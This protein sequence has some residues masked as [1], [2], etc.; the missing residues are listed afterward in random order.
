MPKLTA[1]LLNLLN[2]CTLPFRPRSSYNNPFAPFNL[3]EEPSEA[4]LSLISSNISA[5]YPAIRTISLHILPP[6]F[7]RSPLAD[8]TI[9]GKGERVVGGFLDGWTRRVGD[10]IMSKWIVII[11]CISMG[12]N[13]WLLSEV[14]RGALQPLPQEK[15]IPV[16]VPA[17]PVEKVNHEVK[18][19]PKVPAFVVD[20]SE[21]DDDEKHV[22]ELKRHVRRTR[23]ASECMQ[24][25]SEGRPQDLLDGEIIALTLQKKIPLYA[26]EKTLK[27]LERAVKIRRAAVSRDSI[28]TTLESSGLP[29]KRYDYARVMGACC[30]NVIGYVP[31]PVGVAGPCIIDGEEFWLPMATTEGCLVASTMRG[32]KAMN[33]GGGVTTTLSHDGMTRGPCVKFPSI[34][35]SGAA[36]RWLDSEEGFKVVKKAFDSTSRFARLNGLKTAMAGNRLFIRFSAFTGDGMGMNM[37]SKGVEHALAVITNEAGFGDM[38]IVSISGNFCTDKKPAAVNW[39]LGRGKSVC[40]EAI[41]PAKTVRGVLKSSVDEMVQLNVEKNLIGSAIAGSIGGFN[42]HAANL[43]TAVFIATGQDPAQNVESSNC[44]TLMDKT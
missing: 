33:A 8:D 44:M 31:I 25:I 5:T 17:K 10:P 28:T 18:P 38:E 9:F 6:L 24:L 36:K 13:A 42:A 14:R 3:T 40:A 19:L 32:A 1:V 30:E 43:V 39:I 29:Y 11:L 34:S 2:L 20:E 41:V 23:S 35:R 4:T 15:P 21:S 27:D 12:L 37:I 22:T 16:P 7:L 26:L